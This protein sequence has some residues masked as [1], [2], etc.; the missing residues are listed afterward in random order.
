MVYITGDTHGVFD[1]IEEFCARFK[2]TIYDIMIINGDAGINTIYPNRDRQIKEFLAELPITL[3][4]V[5]GNHENRPEHIMSYRQSTFC[6]GRVWWDPEFPDMY[7]AVDGEVYD[8]G[9]I[10]T[11]VI[12][13]AYS[14]DKPLRLAEGMMWFS[15]EQ[16]SHEAKRNA[17]QN[18]AKYGARIGAVCTHTCPERYLPYEAF[19]SG[20]DQSTVDQ[21]TEKWLDCIADLISPKVWYCS[22]FHIN[23]VVDKTVFLY[24]S[25]RKFG[26]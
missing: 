10:R 19:L 5:H 21:S 17:E 4:C 1:R 25:I 20:I 9:N 24:D 7:F 16:P 13:G 8:F 14:V 23:K 22:H 26:E 15:D 6:G 11:L 18:I 2:T 3:F 12:G